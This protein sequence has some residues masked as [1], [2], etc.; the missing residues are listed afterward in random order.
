MALQTPFLQHLTHSVAAFPQGGKALIHQIKQAHLRFFGSELSDS[1]AGAFAAQFLGLENRHRVSALTG[2][3]PIE[4]ADAVFAQLTARCT[5]E[6]DQVYED[7]YLDFFTPVMF[8]EACDATVPFLFGIMTTVE[9]DNSNQC[10]TVKQTLKL[11]LPNYDSYFDVNLSAKRGQISLDDDNINAIAASVWRAE[12]VNDSVLQ[13]LATSPHAECRRFADFWRNISEK[14]QQRV[15]AELS[16]CQNLESLWARA[17]TLQDPRR[18]YLSQLALT[19][20]TDEMRQITA[21]TGQAFEM[22][23][24]FIGCDTAIFCGELPYNRL[25]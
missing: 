21:I 24:T 14:E 7:T 23:M 18:H 16:Q 4:K 8:N 1:K 22:D 5:R 3:T 2:K 19:V 17:S 6:H 25:P 11:D 12:N 10:F 20:A 13:T 9:R 15:Q